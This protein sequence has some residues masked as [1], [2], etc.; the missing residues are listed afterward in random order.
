MNAATRQPIRLKDYK[1]PPYLI[2]NTK[3]RFELGE[4]STE[5]QS[6]LSLQRNPLAEEED[7][8]LRLHGEGIELLELKLNGTVLREADYQKDEEFLILKN[9]PEEGELSIRTRIRPQDN[10]TLEGLYKSNELFCTQC[11]AEGFRHITFSLDRPDVLSK[12]TTTI[13]GDK[14]TYPTL[15]SNGNP[16]DSGSL[17]DGRHY[18]T[19]EDPFPKPSYLFALVAGNLECLEDSFLTV[20]GKQVALRIYTEH[21]YKEQCYHAME[22][23]KKAMRWDEERFGL[24]YDLEIYMIVAVQDFNFGAMENKGLNIFNARYILSRFDTATDEDFENIQSVVAHEYFH[25]YTGNRVT[26]RDWFQLSLKEG[27]TVFRDQEFTSDLNSRPV[28]RI[29]DVRFLRDYQFPEDAGPTAH[30]VRPESFLEINN[31]YT[32]T[33][34]EKGSELI[35]MLQTL[36]GREAFTQGVQHYLKKHDGQAATV[37]NFLEAIAE[38]SMTDLEPFRA[39]YRQAGTPKV[40]VLGQYS[41]NKQEYELHFE[42]SYSQLSSAG[43]RQAVPIP[44]Q[45]GLLNSAGESVSSA[46]TDVFLLEKSKDSLVLTEISEQPIPS[47]LRQFSAPVRLEYDYSPEE[48]ALLYQR[49]SDEFNRWDAGQRL[50]TMVIEQSLQSLQQGQPTTEPTLLLES[51]KANLQSEHA[52]LSYLSQLLTLPSEGYLSSQFQPISPNQLREALWGLYD[53]LSIQLSEIWQQKYEEIGQPPADN[54]TAEAIGKRRFRNLCLSYLG[55]SRETTGEELAFHQ[56]EQSQNMTEAMGALNVLTHQSGPLRHQA[57]ESFYS[58]WQ[59]D[60]LV[61]DKW[62][63]IQTAS[64]RENVLDEVEG[65]LKHEK[66][67]YRTPNRVRALVGGFSQGNFF[68]FHQEDGRGYQWLTCQIQALDKSNPQVAARLLTPLVRWQ[69]FAEPFQSNMHQALQQIANTS[70]LSKDVFEIINK[71]L[72]ESA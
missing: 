51:F 5:V 14:Q 67:S 42:Q 26:C 68:R 32:V 4:E 30:P 25:N 31:F 52:D 58:K 18:V 64:R 39:W 12:Y 23:L 66:F 3:L 29:Q 69:Q 38:S 54:L 63:R 50:A 33:V 49:D 61:L 41:A 27:L 44:I 19:W 43:E 21:G 34:Y 45:I 15:L 62:F 53:A 40:S 20:S 48:L 2:P 56:F 59:N 65:L 55:R 70:D 24:E 71:S 46:E 11:E 16:T 22:S 47:L 9:F 6:I 37:E 8:L 36:I 13:V 7:R 35:R 60:A 10:T 72:G 1:V 57:L 28:K 17:S